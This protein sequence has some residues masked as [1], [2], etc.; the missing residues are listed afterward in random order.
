M[1]KEKGLLAVAEL[2]CPKKLRLIY[3]FTSVRMSS[4]AQCHVASTEPAEF[5]ST[6]RVCSLSR[7]YGPALCLDISMSASFMAAPRGLGS[8]LSPYYSVSSDV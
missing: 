3:K 4:V 5:K 8:F 2:F 1:N 6:A 7:L